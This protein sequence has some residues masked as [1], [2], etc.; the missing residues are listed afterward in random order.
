VKSQQ[1]FVKVPDVVQEGHRA[2]SVF[3][4]KLVML[5]L[6]FQKMNPQHQT[7]FVGDDFGL[8]QQRARTGVKRM[9]FDDNLDQRIIVPLSCSMPVLHVRRR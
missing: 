5:L 1:F 6:I 9:R 4:Q 2:F 7:E 3:L 8:L